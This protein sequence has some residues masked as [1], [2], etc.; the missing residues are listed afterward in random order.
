M[1]IS[2][3]KIVII[4]LFLSIGIIFSIR[5]F[6]L[7]VLDDTNKV[8]AAN[9]SERK[10]TIYPSRG[11][12]YDRNQEILV[13][14]IAVYDLLI[15]PKDEHIT[16][17]I[18]FCRLIGITK[19]EFIAGVTAAKKYSMRKPSV[20]EKQIPSE[21]YA[22]IAEHLHK[23]PGFFGQSRTLR[24]YP[25]HTAA[26]SLGYVGEVNQSILEND[27]YYKPGDYIGANG[28]EKSYEKQLRGQRGLKFILVDVYNNEK[29]S[30]KD[31]RF[32]SLSVSGYN[33]ETTLNAELQQYGE[34]LLQNKRGS[35][36]A[37]EPK[38][39]EILAMVTQPNYDPNLLIGRIRNKNYVEL[40]RDTLKPLFNRA[41]MAKYPPGSTFKLI[42]GLIGLQE[43]TLTTD[44]YYSCN[45]GF[46]YANRRLGCHVHNSPLNLISA[47]RTSCNAYFCNVF[48]SII[49]KY[50][51]SAEGFSVW[52]K[53]VTS[54]GLGSKTGV[55]VPGEVN[56][57]VPSHNFYDRLYHNSWKALTV[58][59]LAIGQG[60]LGVTPIQMANMTAAIANRGYYI[61]PH[62]VR[63]INGKE[64][65]NFERREIPIDKKHF[66]TVV[67]GMFEVVEAGTGRGVRFS[68]DI[69]VGG[70]TGTAQNPHGK[71]HSIFIAFAPIDNPKIAVAVYVENV[72][73]GSTWAA[74]IN[75]LMIEKYLNDTISRPAIEERMFNANLLR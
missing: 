45:Q 30:F 39:G 12:I 44:T 35:I 67:N 50:P 27:P 16:D 65:T 55:D 5:L 70:K 73:F 51:T 68:E 63:K 75:S 15:V 59:S 71:D 20:F 43:G 47:I 37:I 7:Q 72:G 56:G 69:S 52:N 10:I 46:Y 19:E 33:L 57:F 49:E 9:M 53:Y 60:E 41:L 29:G 42:N 21:Q 8:E 38:T 40:S 48:K 24:T 4:L 17:T 11:L 13:A 14:N 32:D 31:G 25:Y 3:R 28:L 61:T 18:G 23:Y 1:E 22:T 2:N 36:V 58:I 6:Y 34:K 74:P 62:V 64:L 54:F 66:E 26:H